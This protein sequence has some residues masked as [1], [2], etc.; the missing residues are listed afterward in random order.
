MNVS[1]K[2]KIIAISIVS[3]TLFAI[4]SVFSSRLLFLR[5]IDRLYVLDY[6]ERIDNFRWEY[7]SIDAVSAATSEVQ[8]LQD[9]LLARLRNR[10]IDSTEL[11]AAPYIFNGDGEV[12][13]WAGSGVEGDELVGSATGDRMRTMQAGHLEFSWNGREYWTIFSYYEP[14]DWYTGYYITNAERHSAVRRTTVLLVIAGVAAVALLVV[15]YVLYLS[16]VLSP[17]KRCSDTMTHVAAGDLTESLVV[18]SKDEIGDIATSFN[19][20]VDGLKEILGGIQGASRTTTEQSRSLSERT[21]TAR[22]RLEDVTRNASQIRSHV[23]GLEDT[24]KTS[25][26]SMEHISNAMSDLGKQI[27]DQF[28]AVTESSAAV[29]QMSASLANVANIARTKLESTNSLRQNGRLGAEK[30][31][32]TSEA[33]REIQSR[34]AD[35][36]SFVDVIRGIADQTNLLSMNA[37]IEAAHAG[38]TGKGFSVVAEEIRKLAEVASE[39]ASQ[40]A[41]TIEGMEEK[42]ARATESGQSADTFFSE[43][44]EAIQEVVDSFH[45]IVDSTA[46]LSSGSDE[47]NKAISSLNDI[48]VRVKERSD[49]TGS[50]ITTLTASI[51][52]VQALSDQVAAEIEMIRSE[53]NASQADVVA[54]ADISAELNDSMDRLNDQVQR[55]RLTE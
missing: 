32:D 44:D 45:E 1:L 6:R 9:E 21:T 13:L 2:A 27:D 37:A 54:I 55:Y 39:Q 47:I 46:E 50:E 41:S 48:S 26:L 8:R 25:N 23:G 38:E 30:V 15:G 22:S 12:I 14:W 17:L 33:I 36:S 11:R 5:E 31:S 24:V 49:E 42:T 40:I 28:A 43:L 4:F 51:R 3:I 18:R 10:Y 53:A 7:E 20:L 19:S 16:R 35:V 29:E 52:E 34:V